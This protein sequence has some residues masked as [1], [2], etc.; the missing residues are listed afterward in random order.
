VPKDQRQAERFYKDG[1]H[2]TGC[3]TIMRSANDLY[4][5]WRNLE[6]LPRFIDHLHSVEQIS[7]TV[8]RWVTKGPFGQEA[9]WEAEIIDDRPGER[10]VWRTRPG[11]NVE[12][13]GTISFDPLSPDRGTIV[14][15]SLEYLPPGGKVVAAFGKMTGDD[16]QGQVRNALHRFRQ[17]METGEVAVVKGQ[18]VGAGRDDGAGGD[19]SERMTDSDVRDVAG[20]DV[21]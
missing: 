12:S 5:A 13:A 21:Q 15:V 1:I 20:K 6:D 8:S 17:V 7:P 3:T 18:S 10:I 16:A 19:D 2:A 11:S 14:R 4:Q 9:T